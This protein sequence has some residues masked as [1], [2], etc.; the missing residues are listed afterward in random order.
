MATARCAGCIP[1]GQPGL[2]RPGL[3]R[4]LHPGK[5]PA[6]A[7]VAQLLTERLALPPASF[8]ALWAR[9]GARAWAA[10]CAA[11]PRGGALRELAAGLDSLS[12]LLGPADVARLLLAQPPLLGAPIASWRGFLDACEF[13]A[14]QQRE[15]I[16]G[17]PELLATGDLVTAGAAL[18]HLADLGFAD[19]AARHRVVAW[20]P[21]VLLLP[22]DQITDLIRLWSK[23]AVGVDERAGM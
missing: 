3:C 5:A 21:R 18:R 1:G 11:G 20:N 14:A 15:I 10:A 17:C 7:S 23:F 4:S 22:P 2:F 12:A 8:D 13:S 16:S 6:G 9:G 19:D